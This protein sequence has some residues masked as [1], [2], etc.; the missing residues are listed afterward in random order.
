MKKI[1]IAIILII[2]VIAGIILV[3]I[4]MND[5]YDYEIEVIS[6]YNY[7]IYRN[8]QKYGVIDKDGNT[9]IEANYTKPTKRFV[10]LL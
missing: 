7:F 5:K 4:N 2:I 10:L 3:K 1:L 8:N 9:V 6:E